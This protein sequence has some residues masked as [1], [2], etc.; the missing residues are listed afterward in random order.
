E[1]GIRDLIVTGVQTCALPIYFLSRQAAP[2]EHY[3]RVVALFHSFAATG[4][5]AFLAWYEYPNGWLAPIW[6]A[7]AL[8]LA[9]ADQRLKLQELPWQSHAL[10]EIGR[11]HV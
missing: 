1:D 4:L 11:A 9:I 6:A 8:V 5:L 10:A 2:S 3:K 7:F